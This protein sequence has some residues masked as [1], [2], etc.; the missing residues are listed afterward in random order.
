[1]GRPRNLNKVPRRWAIRI[2]RR[3]LRLLRRGV[4][5]SRRREDRESLP[6]SV[7]ANGKNITISAQRAWLASHSLTEYSLQAEKREWNQAGFEFELAEF[8]K[9]IRY[10]SGAGSAYPFAS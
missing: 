4:L 10:R 1:M 7:A 8:S 9:I 3:T 6:V 5:S 2:R